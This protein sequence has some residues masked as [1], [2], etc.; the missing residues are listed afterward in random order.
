MPKRK[1]FMRR[2]SVHH[3]QV[4]EL[5]RLRELLVEEAIEGGLAQEYVEMY[6]NADLAT[7]V[8]WATNRAIAVTE[9]NI[10]QSSDTIARLRA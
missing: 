10:R 3:T 6:R 4:M 1:A 2:I 5:D 8:C 7:L 9:S